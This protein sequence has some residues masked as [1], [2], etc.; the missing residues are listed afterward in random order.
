MA[1]FLRC[2]AA[3]MS[4]WSFLCSKWFAQFFLLFSIFH[5]PHCPSGF[6]PLRSV[7][8]VKSLAVTPPLFISLHKSFAAFYRFLAP[9]HKRKSGRAK[10]GKRRENC[11]S[12]TLERSRNEKSGIAGLN[13]TIE[14]GFFPDPL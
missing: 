6:C 5:H 12:V 13:Q 9:S 11:C 14:N 7:K 2:K 3:T 4:E 10:S 1:F 8:I